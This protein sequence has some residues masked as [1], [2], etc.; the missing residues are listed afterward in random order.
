[1]LDFFFLQMV[2][3]LNPSQTVYGCQLCVVDYHHFGKNLALKHSF[4]CEI[5]EM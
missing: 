3:C 5:C 1:M 2:I 4:L